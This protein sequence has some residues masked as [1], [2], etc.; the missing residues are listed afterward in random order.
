MKTWLKRSIIIGLILGILTSPLRIYTWR[1]LEPGRGTIQ[2][3]ILGSTYHFFYNLLLFI[4]FAILIGYVVSLSYRGLWKSRL[5]RRLGA[6]GFFIGLPAVVGPYHP[7]GYIFS[8]P[9]SLILNPL[10]T[11]VFFD[12]IKNTFTLI[13]DLDRIIIGLLTPLLYLLVGFIIGYFIGL[14]KTKKE[15]IIN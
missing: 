5:G 7:I 12:L 1:I 6:I 13:P 8:I 4:P 10:L 14:N 15:E 11:T 3:L 2:G 9:S